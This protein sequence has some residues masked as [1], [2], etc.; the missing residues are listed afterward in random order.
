MRVLLT[1]KERRRRQVSNFLPSPGRRPRHRSLALRGRC[2]ELA[3]PGVTRSEQET[4][5]Q[6]PHRGRP[7]GRFLPAPPPPGPPQ[8]PCS[9]PTLDLRAWYVARLVFMLCGIK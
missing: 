5:W 7:L 1:K 2:R 3:A 9:A 6:S 8:R 4:P